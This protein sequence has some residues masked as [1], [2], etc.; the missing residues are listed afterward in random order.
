MSGPQRI[1][2]VVSAL[3]ALIAGVWWICAG[4]AS[5]PP[6]DVPARVDLIE[7]A[8]LGVDDASPGKET[9]TSV[10]QASSAQAPVAQ[11]TPA[12]RP[13]PRGG[14]RVRVVDDQDRVVA[15]IAVAMTMAVSGRADDT[16]VAYAR[17]DTEG[18]ADLVA[19]AEKMQRLRMMGVSATFAVGV[20]A[21]LPDAPRVTLG[22][23]LTADAPITLRLPPFGSAIARVLD[24]AGAPIDDGGDVFL[25]W[26]P[27]GSDGRWDRIGTPRAPSR[28]GEAVLA[29]VP[30]GQELLLRASGT[31]HW[32]SGEVIVRGPQAAGEVVR[33]DLRVGPAWAFVVGQLVDAHGAPFVRPQV[34]MGIG[35]LAVDAPPDAEPKGVDTM[36]RWTKLDAAG[37]FRV[38]AGLASP[39]G[40]R[41]VLVAEHTDEGREAAFQA[42]VPLPDPL[43]SGVDFD[44]GAVTFVAPTRER[45]LCTGRVVDAAGQGLVGIDVAA[46]YHDREL[47]RW[48]GLHHQRVRTDD[49]GDFEVRSALAAPV[50]FTLSAS[51]HDRV[52]VRVEIGEGSHRVLTLARGG[53][54]QAQ[55]QAPPGVP[56]QLLVGSIVD[57]E[58]RAREPNQFG[59]G[60]GAGNLAPGRYDVVVRI[61]ESG[62]E[63]ARVPG[64][65]VSE[66]QKVD[67]ERLTPIDVTGRCRGLQVRLLDAA[68]HPIA[69]A[70]V[71]V[72][73]SSG[74]GGR[75][76][77]GRAI[78]GRAI[79]G[80]DGWLI[81]VVPV[82]TPALSVSL[83]D[84]RRA[85]V[86]TD[87]D[88][89]TLTLRE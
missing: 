16:R 34:S 40:W 70:S 15:D 86:R 69:K 36:L 72:T 57:A 8:G 42:I 7:P 89:Q 6:R 17:T 61:A 25:F 37:R 13:L 62:V 46:G 55:I 41:R 80:P 82:P 43:A 83:D 67:D 52:P 77:S 53:R 18:T 29:T 87:V 64:I 68:G 3:A 27:P 51:A 24:P 4:E 23:A 45:V 12:T 78:S 85:E 20:D 30:L 19:D 48:V 39:A 32:Q 26:R 38:R 47:G 74:R 71:Q 59:G 10:A 66:G 21:P 31:K 1:A 73:A 76:I 49:N 63:I 22:S 35:T 14:V 88:K 33:V 81:W 11:R 56:V 58:G 44:V 5:P 50:S 28:G 75:A 84:G 2:I 65:V 9:A 54:L 60:F 79:T